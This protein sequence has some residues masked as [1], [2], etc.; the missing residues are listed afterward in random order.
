MNATQTPGYLFLCPNKDFRAGPTSLRWPDC[1]AYWSLDPLGVDRLS[2]EEATRLGFPAL[3]PSTKIH[4]VSW[5]AGVYAGLRQ[6]HQ[7][8]GFDPNSQNIALRLDQ[9]LFRLSG[10][11]N[12]AFTH[13][14]EL[15]KDDDNWFDDDTD[16]EHTSEDSEAE[17][18]SSNADDANAAD[19]RCSVGRNISPA[20]VGADDK[21]P[22]DSDLEEN[23]GIEAGGHPED[24]PRDGKPEVYKPS[25]LRSVHMSHCEDPTPHSVDLE[26]NMEPQIHNDRVSG[27]EFIRRIIGGLRQSLVMETAN[28]DSYTISPF[29]V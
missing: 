20:G 5:D 28:I 8:K 7:A 12:P 4:G 3:Q 16:K 22:G 24:A 14:G 23:G 26:A 27:R 29:L 6:F 13:V 9:P 10:D 17:K 15:S 1:P 21:I 25:C 2:M 19:E 11:S 18:S